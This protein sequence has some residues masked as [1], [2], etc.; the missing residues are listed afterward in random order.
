MTLQILQTENN[1]FLFTEHNGKNNQTFGAAVTE[2]VI[3]KS[4]G[5]YDKDGKSDSNPRASEVYLFLGTLP[6]LLPQ[7]IEEKL[8]LILNRTNRKQHYLKQLN[9]G[10]LPHPNPFYSGTSFHYDEK[11]RIRTQKL[12][13]SPNVFVPLRKEFE[14]LTPEERWEYLRHWEPKTTSEILEEKMK[15]KI[16]DRHGQSILIADL[17]GVPVLSFN[18]QVSEVCYRHDI[19]HYD[20]QKTNKLP[21]VDKLIN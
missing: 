3:L 10:Y 6:I 13:S 18:N 15:G 11:Y 19:P 17:Y 1:E 9:H 8:L 12:L 4:I 20:M 14:S 21:S 2:D 7:P 5:F 16:C